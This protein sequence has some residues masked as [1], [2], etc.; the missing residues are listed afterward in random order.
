[1]VVH[2]LLDL[3]AH[4]RAEAA[5]GELALQGGEQVLGVVLLDLEVLVAGDPEGEVLADLHAR[6]EL[7]EVRGDD[8]LE[9]HE[10][11]VVHV[12]QRRLV[13]PDS[14]RT[15]RGST[16]GTLTRAKCSLPVAG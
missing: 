13:G 6:E 2:V 8:V 1:M 3:E 5:P 10:P 9:G 7:V 4:R 14:T 11:G 16:G 12:G 15:K